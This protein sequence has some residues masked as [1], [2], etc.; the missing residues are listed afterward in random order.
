MA[1]WLDLRKPAASQPCLCHVYSSHKSIL[2]YF[3]TMNYRRLRIV[4]VLIGAKMHF[5]PE[6]VWPLVKCR[7]TAGAL[8]YLNISVF[9]CRSIVDAN[10]FVISKR[11]LWGW[12]PSRICP[13]HVKT[14]TQKQSKEA[15]DAGPK[16]ALKR[17][18]FSRGENRND[19]TR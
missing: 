9:S 15:S 7:I 14:D 1:D 19:F 2:F 5:W 6:E 10:Y 8:H 17:C 18:I 3:V 11:L 13:V 4:D 12:R 16:S